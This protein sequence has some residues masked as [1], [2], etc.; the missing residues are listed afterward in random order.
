ML[1]RGVIIQED[2]DTADTSA[3]TTIAQR[4]RPHRRQRRQPGDSSRASLLTFGTGSTHN[5]DDR[6]HGTTVTIKCTVAT[7]SSTIRFLFSQ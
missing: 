4:I 5:R 6:K 1:S 7:D 3:V 2:I